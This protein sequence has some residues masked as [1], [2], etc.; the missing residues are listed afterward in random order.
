MEKLHFFWQALKLRQRLILSCFIACAVLSCCALLTAICLSFPYFSSSLAA[1]EVSKAKD[2]ANSDDAKVSVTPSHS[3]ITVDVS[4]GVERP[5]V[6]HL[7]AEARIADAIAAAGQL[8]KYAD[9]AE[10]MQKL[11]LAQKLEDGQKVYIPV[12]GWDFV[13][14]SVASQTETKKT[15]TTPKASPKSTPKVTTRK[16]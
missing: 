2:T 3:F 4:G 8:S 16:N 5:G 13:P 1:V 7:S 6:Y 9:L 12:A 10:V 14:D 11:N 15:K